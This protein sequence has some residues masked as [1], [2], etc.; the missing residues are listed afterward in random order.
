MSEIHIITFSISAVKHITAA[1]RFFPNTAE[2]RLVLHCPCE[3]DIPIVPNYLTIKVY[4]DATHL[5][6]SIK[7]LTQRRIYGCLEDYDIVCKAQGISYN[8]IYHHPDASLV[9]YS[10]Q[11]ELP[12]GNICF[13]QSESDLESSRIHK[14]YANITAYRKE[15]SKD[16]LLIT[17]NI[18]LVNAL[19]NIDMVNWVI[20]HPRHNAVNLALELWDDPINHIQ[21]S[22]ML[23]D[24]LLHLTTRENTY[25][26]LLAEID[27]IRNDDTHSYSFFAKHYDEYMAHVVYDK[28]VQKILGWFSLYSK[29]KLERIIEL[30]CGTANVSNRLVLQGYHVDACDLSPEMLY[31]ADKKQLKPNLYRASLTDVIPNTDYE[32]AICMFDSVNYLLKVSDISRM[33]ERVHACLKV[34]GIFIFDISTVFNSEENFADV[35]NL[36]KHKEGYLVHKAWF[37]PDKARQYSSLTCFKKEF[38]GYSFQHEM[39]KQRVYWCHELISLIEKSPLKLKAIHSSESKINFYPRHIQGIDDKYSRLFFILQRD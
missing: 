7:H 3:V 39:H 6:E 4:Q 23:C 11:D 2:S 33:L 35:C 22:I 27:T 10:P 17:K 15:R 16:D 18:D 21:S 14:V 8:T 37:D 13:L 34:G 12:A 30:A 20:V 5:T 32:L 1:L 36:S 19:V 9:H 28:W 26:K 29:L 38:I 31:V 25:A 24:R